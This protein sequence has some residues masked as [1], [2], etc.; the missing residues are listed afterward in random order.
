MFMFKKIVL[1][2]L[3]LILAISLGACDPQTSDEERSGT[4]AETEAS[5]ENVAEI[6][7]PINED[8]ERICGGIAGLSCGEG[9]YCQ[10]AEGTCQV[11]DNMGVCKPQLPMCTKDYRPVCGCDGKTYGNACS[12]AAEG[13]SLDHQGECE[14]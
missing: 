8:G 9:E 6:T 1:S 7:F 3:F 2:A 11:A 12:A 14:A 4:I 5:V 13:V 10:M